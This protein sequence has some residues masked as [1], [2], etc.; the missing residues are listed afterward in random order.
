[1]DESTSS[2]MALSERI[3]VSMGNI[4]TLNSKTNNIGTILDVIRSISEQTNLLAL[5]AA[6]E[7]ARAGDAGRGFAVVADEVRSLA[8][9]TQNSTSDIHAMIAELQEDARAAVEVMSQSEAQC[10]VTAGT[11]ERAGTSLQGMTQLVSDIDS[12]GLS[13]A[14]A[15]EE[16][17]AVVET[18]NVD[19][20]HI[21]ELNDR[22]SEK[23]TLTM[24]ACAELDRQASRLSTLV[25]GFK[26]LKG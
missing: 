8:H 10:S 26:I 6:I 1:M 5:N 16:Q 21:S 7:A 20:A 12:I 17:T 15:T 18:L 11:I 22:C 2:L 13:V 24:E 4:E 9:R 3:N 25:N 19:L 14:A 23:L